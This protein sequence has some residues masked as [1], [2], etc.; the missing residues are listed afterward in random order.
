MTKI[1]LRNINGKYWTNLSFKITPYL[2]LQNLDQTLYSKSEQKFSFMTIPQLP[3]LQQTVANMIHITN[4]SK[5]NNPN[6]FWIGIFTRQGHINQVEKTCCTL[7]AAVGIIHLFLMCS[8]A[9]SA[10]FRFQVL[11]SGSGFFNLRK[12]SIAVATS[13]PLNRSQLGS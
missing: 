8:S 12:L 13:T 4:I 6:K 7:A 10:A 2:Q 5:S 11:V 3:N 1:Q 9:S